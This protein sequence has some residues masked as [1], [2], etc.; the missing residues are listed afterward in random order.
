MNIY[1]MSI[2]D[3]SIMEWLGWILAG[4]VGGFVFVVSLYY[5]FGGKR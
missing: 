5:V 3:M 1:G 4:S 2:Y